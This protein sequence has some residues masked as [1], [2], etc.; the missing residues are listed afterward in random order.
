MALY[1][2]V[3]GNLSFLLIVDSSLNHTFPVVK[4]GIIPALHH[5]GIPYQVMDLARSPLLKR[6]SSFPGIIIGQEH[7]GKSFTPEITRF[8][9]EKIKQGTGL[10]SFDAFLGEYPPEWLDFIGIFPGRVVLTSLIKLK[11]ANHYITSTH[12]KEEIKKLKKPLELTLVNIRK[13]RM[14][15][16]FIDGEKNPAL[17]V[18]FL[19]KGRFVQFVL[20]AKLWILD[21]FGHTEG[22]DDVF[23]KSIIWVAKK[24]VVMKAMPPFVTARIDDAS[25]T[26]N[27]FGKKRNSANKKFRYLDTLNRYGYIPNVGL[28]IDDIISEDI[29]TMRIKYEEGKAEF[30]PHAFTDPQ[31]IGEKLIYMK[32]SGE[33]FS[34][35]ELE[36]NFRRVDKKFFSWGMKPSRVVNAH[37][38]EIGINSL[39]F[40]KERGQIYTMNIIRFG[41]AYADP[42]GR[43]WNP[44]P[45]GYCGFIFDYMPEDN[46]FFNVISHPFISLKDDSTAPRFDFLWGCTPFWKESPYNDV[47]KAAKRGAEQIKRGLDNLFFGCLMTHEQRI[48]TLSIEEWERILSLINETITSYKPIFVGYDY[49]AQ[50]AKSKIESRLTKAHYIPEARK[51]ECYLEGKTN[52]LTKLYIFIER[53]G[54]IEYTLGDIPPFQKS[55]DV[56]FKL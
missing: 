2:E 44:K 23:W 25:G 1:Q 21:Y 16:L 22:L 15:I 34:E 37:F 56:S 31:N 55:I 51:I 50:Y 10:V 14:G 52:I 45:Y 13:E 27:I 48:A 33:E 20:S 24:P 43:D 53:K 4:E 12:P 32:H 17:L 8:L 54:E 49:I 41:R 46:S 40:L 18:G 19:E 36:D 29:F 6:F 7:L 5:F 9:I 47:E 39:P 28:F 42:K 30:S 11:N 26:A 38:A 3:K 35:K